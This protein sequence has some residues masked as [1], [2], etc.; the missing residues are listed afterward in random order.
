MIVRC[1]IP[2]KENSKRVLG[3]NFRKINGKKLYTIIIETA[4]MSGC[5]D[6]VI[7]DTDSLEIQE[8]CKKTGVEFIDRESKY[9]SDAATGNDLIRNWIKL[10]PDTEVIVQTHATSPFTRSETLINMVEIM[11]SGTYDSCLTAQKEQTWYWFDGSPVNYSLNKLTRSQDAKYL[12]K[13]TTATYCITSEAFTRLNRRV[14]DHPYFYFVDKIEATDIDDDL[15]MKIA[16]AL[17]D[18]L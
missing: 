5:F 13:E 12:V 3:K 9:S 10:Y 2:I 4:L 18:S 16:T 15:D 17:G 7:V 8:Y 11:K 14:G 1:F 6:D